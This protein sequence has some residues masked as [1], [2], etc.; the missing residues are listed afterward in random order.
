MLLVRFPA[1]LTV[2]TVN[3]VLEKIARKCDM[4]VMEALMDLL[5]YSA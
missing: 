1:L 3:A 5:Y 2:A 4:E